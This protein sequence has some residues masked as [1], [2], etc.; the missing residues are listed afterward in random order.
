VCANE[1]CA[2]LK[3]DVLEQRERPRAQGADPGEWQ[4]H[5]LHDNRRRNQ[6]KAADYRAIGT[7]VGACR[8]ETGRACA[9]QRQASGQ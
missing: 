4:R 7:S 6:G 2:V 8:A 5:E 3:I 9:T 1:T